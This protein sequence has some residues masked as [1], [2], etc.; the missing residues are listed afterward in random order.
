MREVNAQDSR[1]WESEFGQKNFRNSICE[2]LLTGFDHGGAV[3]PDSKIG[4]L[5]RRIASFLENEDMDDPSKSVLWINRLRLSDCGRG[6]FAYFSSTKAIPEWLVRLR[7]ELP[8][9]WMRDDDPLMR[10]LRRSRAWSGDEEDYSTY[11]KELPILHVSIEKVLSELSELSGRKRSEMSQKITSAFREILLS[12]ARPLDPEPTRKLPNYVVLHIAATHALICVISPRAKTPDLLIECVNLLKQELSEILSP[13]SLKVRVSNARKKK[14]TEDEE[15]EPI[16]KAP[17]KRIPAQ[18]S[19]P[20]EVSFSKLGSQWKKQSSRHQKD[21]SSYLVYVDGL[22][23]GKQC[24]RDDEDTWKGF[25]RSS[26][27]TPLM[28]SAMGRILA[29][30][31]HL[32]AIGIHKGGDDFAVIVKGSRC[33]WVGQ[34]LED[35]HKDY[36]DSMS[37]VGWSRKNQEEPLNSFFSPF[38]W[39]GVR[40]LEEKPEDHI[41]EA[42]KLLEKE[43]ITDLKNR[44]RESL[45]RMRRVAMRLDL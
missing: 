26:K 25:I 28:D 42:E 44:R 4:V 11:L 37:I 13:K 29:E 20:F 18:K 24:W 40:R 7:S 14:N 35:N 22:W 1:G 45:G 34:L 5:T 10:G 9:E 41:K 31:S 19:P 38:W 15:N 8:G 33:A 21:N 43:G 36:E 3:E 17:G 16:G 32:E 30:A 2:L 23:F 27:I 39:W 6:A 12:N